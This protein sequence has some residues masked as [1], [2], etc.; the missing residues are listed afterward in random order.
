MALTLLTQ[1]AM[2]EVMRSIRALL[3]SAAHGLFRGLAIVVLVV[4]WS[5][6]HVGT[7]ALSV[8]GVSSAL[9][10]TTATPADAQWRRWRRWAPLATLASQALVAA[11]HSLNYPIRLKARGL[12][13]RL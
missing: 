1:Q 11:P 3:S 7:Y 9:L 5:L 6:S 8:V 10:T 4:V 2:V 13:G 12:A